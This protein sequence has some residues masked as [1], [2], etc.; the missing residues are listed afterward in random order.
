M[1]RYQE[2]DEFKIECLQCIVF[3]DF[4]INAVRDLTELINSKISKHNVSQIVRFTTYNQ[5]LNRDYMRKT[6]FDT[7]DIFWSTVRTRDEVQKFDEVVINNSFLYYIAR[8]HYLVGD[9]ESSS[10]IKFIE[11]QFATLGIR[12]M[13]TC[14]KVRPVDREI[15]N[16]HLGNGVYTH[17]HFVILL[18]KNNKR[19]AYDHSSN[20][21]RVSFL[22]RYLIMFSHTKGTSKL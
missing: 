9:R 5:E 2:S 17:P 21:M 1:S 18:P 14:G 16:C 20:L 6:G 8:H 13:L 4:L 7:G 12:L 15:V 3:N 22:N 11:Y 19:F 10:L